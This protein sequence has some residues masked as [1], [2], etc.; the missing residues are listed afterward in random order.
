[1]ETDR[2]RAR[3][4]RRFSLRTLL[5]LTTIACVLLGVWSA[6]VAPYRRQAL[7]TQ[8]VYDHGGTCAMRPAEGAEWCR[9]LV[10]KLVGKDAFVDLTAIDLNGAKNSDGLLRELGGLRALRE[11][12]LD[13]S[14]VTDRG[15]VEV[16]GMRQLEKLSLRYTHMTDEGVKSLEPLDQ[17]RE[18]VL[19][20]TRI[21]DQAIA[22]LEGKASLESLF[23]RWTDIS[24]D[25]AAKLQAALP[26]A[27]IYY[28]GGSG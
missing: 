7:A 22:A 28:Y 18:L 17:L 3:R 23:I 26:K 13:R 16:A 24:T 25:G 1:M 27:A 9:W 6:Y 10:T 14:D 20:G 2:Q 11:L 19:T 21:S 12:T 4:W 8:L 5:L 15:L